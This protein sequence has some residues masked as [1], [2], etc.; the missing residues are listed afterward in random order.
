MSKKCV[1]CGAE[2]KDDSAFCGKCG[3]KLKYPKTGL[4][5]YATP[6]IILVALVVIIVLHFIF[7]K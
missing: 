3:G 2:G 6:I 4:A 1:D 7:D 5:R